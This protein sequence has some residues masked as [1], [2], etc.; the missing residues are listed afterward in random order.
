[1]LGRSIELLSPLRVLFL[2]F[3]VAILLRIIPRRYLEQEIRSLGRLALRYYLQ[4]RS[5]GPIG[6]LCFDGLETSLSQTGCKAAELGF[7]IPIH[8]YY[9]YEQKM[10]MLNP[11]IRFHYE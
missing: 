1:M 9:S 5:A 4:C 11:I 10:Y 7:K 3:Y 6:G 2:T 8:F